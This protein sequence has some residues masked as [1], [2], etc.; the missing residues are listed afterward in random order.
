VVA[1]PR[2]SL[3][4]LAVDEPSTKWVS[5]K[6]F[7]V[8]C[9]REASTDE[10]AW[11]NIPSQIFGLRTHV[12]TAEPERP[13]RGHPFEPPCRGSWVTPPSR[14]NSRMWRFVIAVVMAICDSFCKYAPEQ[15]PFNLSSLDI[16][17]FA[18][19]LTRYHFCCMASWV[20][21]SA[22]ILRV[23]NVQ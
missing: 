21:F 19:E 16:S 7:Q 12:L 3:D 9:D 5:Q 4:M 8:S 22:C 23:S 11:P 18:C 1:I 10:I 14:V 6:V 20:R 17:S 15:E 13:G 2:A